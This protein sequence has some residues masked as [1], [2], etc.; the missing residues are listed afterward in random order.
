MMRQQEQICLQ[1]RKVRLHE[2]DEADDAYIYDE[3]VLMPDNICSECWRYSNTYL[4]F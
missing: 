1:E 3:Y 2:S 4:M